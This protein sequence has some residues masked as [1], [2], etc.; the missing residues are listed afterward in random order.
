MSLQRLLQSIVRDL[1]P[2]ARLDFHT[3]SG[4]NLFVPDRGAWS[5]VGEV[6]FTR[7]YDPFFP[8]LAG[9]RGWVDLGCNHGFFSFGL[10]D[11]LARQPGDRPVTRVFLGDANDTCVA[12]VRTA[13]EHN[14][15]QPGWRCERVVIGPPDATVVFKL[16]KDS[17]GSNI[18]DRGRGRRMTR[19]ITTDISGRLAQE[20]QLFDLIKI[21]IEGAEQYLFLH[22]L[23]LLKRFRFGLCEWH[24]PVFPGAELEQRLR[25]LGWKVL[26]LRSQGVEYDLRRG[27]SWESPMGMV[28]WENPAPTS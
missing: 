17:L 14:R 16:H 3:E 24:A 27:H 13:I 6:F 5:S 4:L 25:Q 26:E 8:L 18:F 11:R 23:N 21:D 15:L 10:L 12:R 1:L 9:V 28:L 7:V 19:Q 2:Y 22:H 20:P